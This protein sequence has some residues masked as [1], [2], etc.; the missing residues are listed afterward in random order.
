MK[1]G[2]SSHRPAL[3]QLDR[4]PL[5]AAEEAHAHARPHRGRLLRELDA[6]LPE[7]GGDH[8]DPGN[9]QPKMVEALIGGGGRG[10]NT[11]AG[12]DRRDEDVGAAEL[13]VDAR[14]TLLH[15]ADDLSAEHTLEPLRGRLR[16]RAAQVDVV[17]CIG[18]HF[19]SPNNS[20]SKRQFVGW[21]E[22]LRNPS[23][24]PN[25]DDGFRCAQ[26]ILLTT[27]L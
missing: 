24:C 3:Q 25:Y 6:F 17:P 13:E 4:N 10:M 7:L 27:Y 20:L 26:P 9:R 5:R 2:A 21:V 19:L 23:P 11:L 18:R 15:A 22:P 12:L 8:I 16:V 14:L 1:P